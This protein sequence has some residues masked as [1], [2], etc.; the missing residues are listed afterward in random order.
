MA[1]SQHLGNASDLRPDAWRLENRNG[2]GDSRKTMGAR[3]WDTDASLTA[4][5]LWLS[6]STR[7]LWEEI[8]E[9]WFFLQSL[10]LGQLRNLRL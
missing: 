2:I 10:T 3:L 6:R 8:Q 9:C 5:S 4:P 1:R 7:Q